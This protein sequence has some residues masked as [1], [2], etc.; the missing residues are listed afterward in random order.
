[1]SVDNRGGNDKMN[2]M[3]NGKIM[4]TVVLDRERPDE[5]TETESAGEEDV[6]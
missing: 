6:N 1:M 5:A 3:L 4:F 2:Q